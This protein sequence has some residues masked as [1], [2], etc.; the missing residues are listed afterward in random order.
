MRLLALVTTDTRDF[1][2]HHLQLSSCSK[3]QKVSKMLGAVKSRQ[4]VHGSYLNE[5]GFIFTITNSVSFSSIYSV[6]FSVWWQQQWSILQAKLLKQHHTGRTFYSNLN[7]QH[8]GASRHHH[9]SDTGEVAIS[10]VSP[11]VGLATAVEATSLLQVWSVHSNHC[12]V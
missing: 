12:L 8:V 5:L 11:T 6:S 2:G 3:Q 7:L 4:H 9:I 1:S 10:P